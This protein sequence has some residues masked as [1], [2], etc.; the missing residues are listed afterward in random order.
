MKRGILNIIGCVLMVMTISSC[1]NGSDH[2]DVT[3]WQILYDQEVSL[4][5][6]AGHPDWHD[7]TIPSTFQLPYS[8]KRTLQYA[9]L[10]GSFMIERDPSPY[11]G[12]TTGRIFHS[13]ETYINGVFIGRETAHELGIMMQPRNYLVPQKVLHQGKNEILI[14]IGVYGGEHGGISSGVSI[15]DRNRFDRLLLLS[16]FIYIHFPFEMLFGALVIMLVLIIFYIWNRTIMLHLFN[17]GAIMLYIVLMITILYLSRVIDY[18]VIKFLQLSLVP[19]FSIVLVYIIQALYR[20]DLPEIN[21]RIVPFF[22]G[23]IILIFGAIFIVKDAYY[24]SLMG[25]LISSFAITICVPVCMG[26]IKRLNSV[27]PDR[28][29][30]NMLISIVLFGNGLA[31]SELISGRL[32]GRLFFLLLVFTAPLFILVFAVYYARDEMKKNMELDLRY[33]SLRAQKPKVNEESK[34]KIERVLSFIR[35]NYTSD[36]SREGLAAAVDLN[37]NYMS[38]LFKQYT[39]EK[40]NDYINRLRIEEA[41]RKLTER[42]AKII[43]IAFSVGFES[44][45]TFNRV[46]KNVTGKTPTEYRESIL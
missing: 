34:E 41:Q 43:E 21:R 30:K 40:I 5:Q 20:V 2:I 37:P 33:N 9:W 32:S 28:F 8:P 19:V 24:G 46:F 13:D 44:L 14:R 35:E 25:F 17:A 42:D 12:L 18:T 36:L 4:E 15:S 16:N 39:D 26:L 38:T 22:M 3:S 10:K 23:L 31:L 1:G 29:K 6:L 7:I 45:S 27:N 11:V